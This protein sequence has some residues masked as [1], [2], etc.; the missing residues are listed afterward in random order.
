MG[1]QVGSTR[2]VDRICDSLEGSGG[3]TASAR[4]LEGIWGA[5]RVCRASWGIRGERRPTE[6]PRGASE[7]CEVSIRACQDWGGGGGTSRVHRRLGRIKGASGVCRGVA[8]ALTPTAPSE[9]LPCH[10]D[11]LPSALGTS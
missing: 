8:G 2:G 7:G 4:W 1:E 9:S 6:G 5:R 10:S 11:L 3:K